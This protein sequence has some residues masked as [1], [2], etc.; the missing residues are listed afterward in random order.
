MDTNTPTE[1]QSVLEW[2]VKKISVKID[3]EL[4]EIDIRA[5]FSRIGIK[6]KDLL[7]LVSELGTQLKRKLPSTLGFDYPNIHALA[8]FL[9]GTS[10]CRKISFSREGFND[11]YNK[12]DQLKGQRITEEMAFDSEYLKDAIAVVGMGCR[13]PGGCDTP[14]AFWQFLERGG[15]GIAEV[16]ADR[17]DVDFFYDK[18]PAI[19][20]KMTTRWGGF[21]D[22]IDQ[23]DPAFFG[24][25]PREARGVDP[26]QRLIMEVGWETLEDAG[27]IPAQLKGSKTGV[28]VGISGSDYGRLLF[29]EP[30]MLNLYS[31]TGNSTSIAANRLSYFLGLRGPSIALDTACSSSLVAVDLACKD[32]KN[33]NCNLALAGGVN[34]ILSPEMTIIFSKANLMAPDGRCKTFDSSADGYVRSE[35]CGMVALKRYSDA[36]NDGN[37]IY[38]L[39]RGTH[40]NQDG[41]STGLTVPNGLAQEIL[42]KDS[43]GKAGVKPSRVSYAETHGTG[44][45]IGDPIEVNSLGNV[46]GKGRS[47]TGPL[48]IGSVKT[49]IGHLEQAAGIAGLIKVLLSLKH[50]K[51]PS[52]LHFKEI[53]PMIS[54]D[55]I[56]AVIPQ[57]E[58]P[59]LPG[60][61]KRIA[62]VS[63]F[64][65][66][67]VN[68]HVVV[69]EA[70]PQ[71]KADNEQGVPC[72]LLT[73]SARDEKTLIDMADRYTKYLQSHPDT[74]TGSVCYTANAC[75]SDFSQRL[76]I[77]GE[78]TEELKNGLKT[79]LNNSFH[80]EVYSAKSQFDS[81]PAFLFTGQG[82]QYAGM[83]RE[84]YQTQPVFR[85]EM[86]RCNEILLK[87][88]QINLLSLIYD[89]HD[90]A[91][92]DQTAN[93]QPALFSLEYSMACMYQAWGI[94]PSVVMG[95]SVGEFVAAC[96]AGVFS[97]EDGLK[98]I[99]E[100]GRLI[101]K[102][103]QGGKM[104]VFFTGLVDIEAAISP[105][106]QDLSIAA[107]NGLG[108]IVVS[109]IGKAVDEI[110][111]SLSSKG[112]QHVLLPVS[113]AFHSILMEPMLEDFRK[114]AMEITYEIPKIPYV[115]NVTGKMIEKDEVCSPDYWCR[116]IRSTVRFE[117][118]IQSL[119]KGGCNLFLEIG[120][121]PVLSGMASAILP[122]DEA[123]FAPS[124]KK[125][126]TDLRSILGGLG[127]LYTQGVEINWKELHRP[128][129]KAVISLP[130]YPFQRRRY[131][132]KDIE[133][134]SVSSEPENDI[135]CLSQEVSKTIEK[136]T[137][138]RSNSDFSIDQ[139]NNA[140]LDEKETLIFNYIS[141][142]V[143]EVMG[144]DAGMH[145]DP[146]I[147]LMEMGLDSL[148]V[149]ELRD[150]FIKGSGVNITLVEFANN[151]T[152]KQLSETMLERL[153]GVKDSEA[154]DTTLPQIVQQPDQR[155]DPFPLTDIQNAYWMGRNGELSLGHVSCH[156][157]PEVDIVDLDMDR[158][159]KAVSKLINR[160]EILRAV[161]LPYG[162]QQ[163]LEQVP[164][165]YEI[166][167][168]DLR[169]CDPD[170]QKTK[171]DDIR[172]Q[173]SHQINPSDTGPLFEIRA[174][175]L[176]EEI[177][178]LHVSFDLLIGD[179]WSFNILISDLYKYYLDPET[180]LPEL[181][182]SFRDYVLTQEKVKSTR[183]YQ[184]SM[185]YWKNRLSDLLPS[186]DLP[187][188][189]KTDEINKQ[190]FVR[191]KSRME[192]N[193][194]NNLKDRA[195][196]S[197]LTPSG[198]LL[199]AFSEVL[200][201]W[202]K[203]SDFTLNL[204][205]FNRLPLHE[206]VNEIVGDFT[207]TLLLEINNSAH[208]SFEERARKIRDRL[209]E[210]LE[211]R[212]VSG[213]EILR[214]LNRQKSLESND[215]YPIVFTS[216]LPHGDQIK[217]ATT[218][219]LP[220]ELSIDLV[221][222]ISQTP[223]VWLD[224]QIYEQNGELT[225]NWDVVE[226]L[227]PDGM[228]DDMFEVY[229]TLIN[230]LAD[231]EDIWK[232]TNLKLVPETQVEQRKTVNDTNVP[233]SGE[234]LHTLFDK[235]AIQQP[236]KEAIVT[237]K[238]RMNYGELAS[239]SEEIG[240]ILRAE[241]ALSNTLVAVVMEKGWEQVV[242][243]LGI[244]Y[245]GAAYV[246]VD[247]SMPK[248]RLYQ[249]LKNGEVDLVLTQSW[250]EEEISWPEGI[251]SFSVDQSGCSEK[252]EPL[253]PVQ[254]QSD[255]AYVIY[256]S[257]STGQ[258]KGVM[259][260]HKG[261]VNTILDVNSRFHISGKDKVLAL[262]ELSF[263][264][265]VYD[266]FGALSAGGTIIIPDTESRK[267]PAHWHQLM[268]M[269]QVTVWNSAPQLMQMYTEYMSIRGEGLS[270][271]L[272]LVLMSGDWI[273]LDLPGKIKSISPDVKI[274][275]L[276][277]ATE[278]SIWSIFYPVN[279]I[280]PAWKSIPY[281]QP[282]SNQKFY[283]F[284]NDMEV[285]PDWVPGQLYIAG[286]GLAKGYWRDEEKTK[287][288]FLKHF[289][290][291]ETLY[292]TGDLGRF[293]PDGNIEFLGREDF[294]VKIR[295]HRIELGEIEATLKKHPGVRDAVVTTV[296]DPRESRRLVGYVI[297]DHESTSSLFDIENVN[298][299]EKKMLW[300]S[301]LN[302][303]AKQMQQLPKEFTPRLLS[304][305]LENLEYLSFVYICRALISVGA[306]NKPGQQYTATTLIDDCGIQPRYLKLV[307]QWLDILEEEGLLKRNGDDIFVNHEALSANSSDIKISLELEQDPEWKEYVENL[308]L[309]FERGSKYYAQL[310]KGEVDPLWL[311]FS[312]EPLLSPEHLIQLLPVTYFR[313][314][315]VKRFL[316]VV[317]EKSSKEKPLR[318]LEVGART[319]VTTELLLPVLSHEQTIYTYTDESNFFIGKGKD[320]FKDYSFV[321]YQLLDID[322]S[323][324]DQ[325]YD[326]HC[327]DIIITS[328]SLHRA[329]NVEA[330]SHHL[331]SLLAPGGFLFALEMTRNSRLINISV[332]F[333]EEFD[334]FQDQRKENGLPLFSINEWN[335]ILCSSGFENFAA[336]PE[337]SS[338][339]EPHFHQNVMVV[340][341][342]NYVK[343]FNP[344]ELVDI[345]HQNLPKYM[346]PSTFIPL[347]ELPLTANGK[348]DRQKLPIPE[349]V[350]AE[351]G[352][353]FV[354]P[355][356]S[357]EASLADVWGQVLDIERIGI[358]DNF[359]ELGG[360]SLLAVQL[361]T[362]MSNTYNV[363]LSLERLMAAPTIAE[364]SDHIN[365]LVQKQAGREDTVV[366][367]PQITP[368]PG[369]EYIPFPLTDIQQA[370]LIGRSG[371][372]ELGNVSTH[373]Y[374]EF[375]SVG[376]EHERL[377]H[378]WQRLINQHGMMRT[379]ILPDGQQQQILK[380]VPL[381]QI[382]MLDLRGEDQETVESELMRLRDEMS[383]QLISTDQWP[384][385]DVR[386]SCFDK[387][388]VRLHISFDNLIFDGWSMFHL[389]SEWSRLYNDPDA[390]LPPL[391]LS[392]RD[393]VLAQKKINGS[394]L[395]QR[396]EEY[397][398]N[399]LPNIPP[400]PE[401]PLAKNP[402][403]FSQQRFSRLDSRLNRETWQQLKKRAAKLGLTPSGVL[404]TAYAEILGAWSKHPQLTINLTLF[405]RPEIHPQLNDIIGDFTSLT[406]LAVDNS[407]R[408]TFLERGKILQ[409]QL[410]Q[411]LDH[412]YVGGI[413]V[414]RELAKQRGER[415]GALMP[416][417][418]TSALGVDQEHENDSWENW[419]D[420]LIYNISQTPQV[421]LDH[422]VW[423]QNEELV[424]VWD[425]VEGLFPEKLL[426]DMF[427]AYCNLLKRLADKEKAWQ[428]TTFKL[429]PA[430]QLEKR[431]EV[432]A[433]EAPVSSEMLHTLFT[434]QVQQRPNQLAVI[435][436]NRALSYEELWSNSNQ[437]GHLLREKGAQ[438]NALIAVVMEK[439][440]EQIVATLG[441][442]QSGAAYLPIDPKLP[443][444]RLWY[445]LENG[446]VCL[447]LTQS[448][449]EMEI[450]W[451]D[452]LEIFP[453]DTMELTE[454]YSY[455]LEPIQRP[456]DLAYV[457]YTSGSTGYPKGVMIDHRGA[458]NTILDVNKRF[459]VEPKDKILAISNLNFDLS[460]YD[461]FGTLA[462]GGTMVLPDAEKTK[463]PAHWAELIAK[464]QITIWNTVPTMMQM[465]VEYTTGKT[466]DVSLPLC[467]VL[468]SGDWI[469]HD[470]PDKIMELNDGVQ[471]VSLG[472]AT[473]ASI[474]S[475]LYP[476]GK[477][478]LNW[479]SIPYGR[480]IANQHYYVLNAMLEDCPVWVSGQLYIG[481]IGL[482]KGY[483]RDEEK[484]KAA[485]IHHPETGERLYRTGDI[486]RYLPDGD[487]EFLGR[488]DSQVKIGGYRIE[489][490]EIETAL[491]QHQ[492][493]RD[494]VVVTEGEPLSL[495][496]AVVLHKDSSGIVEQ[497]IGK[498]L[499]TFL[500][501]QLP[502]YMI[503]KKITPLE[504]L[505]LNANGKVDKK[506][507][508][509]TLKK[510]QSISSPVISEPPRDA[511]E[512]Q[513]AEIWVDN[514]QVQ[515]LSRNDD[516]F[517]HGGDSLKATRIIGQL[518]TQQ[519]APMGV[520]LRTLFMAPTIATFAEQIRIQWSEKT[521][522][523]E[524]KQQQN[525]EEGVL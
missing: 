523:Q 356:T 433:T 218:I 519:I 438:P 333:I 245:S 374:F 395:Y 89:E 158:F 492:E 200:A 154:S 138:L 100:R 210:D 234:M 303:G 92:L 393:Y 281:G 267:N 462:A 237:S 67:G 178:R 262:S 509:Q 194:W 1:I 369:Q 150:R 56:P 477:V 81:K 513:L 11:L 287:A 390:S 294:Q 113:H 136:P 86:N 494:A 181:E 179:G 68:A 278:A 439:G 110:C 359:F 376:L 227:F 123:I 313:N 78:N 504:A 407:S 496:A 326:T 238:F 518:Q 205:M 6:S 304:V 357:M 52:H 209:W 467:L 222:C 172:N 463:E 212:Y 190:R 22:Q 483:W 305:F 498:E 286:A 107:I 112:I 324:Q 3:R 42:I 413:Q 76:A 487:L 248:E 271:R 226:G 257:G 315:I 396:D 330:A 307:E 346:I 332:G 302:A 372:Y 10:D 128:Y 411:D 511:L 166:K 503:P 189:K 29:Q 424:L 375:E 77:L 353:N 9:E 425:A 430:Y 389:I 479:K 403:S 342:S 242:A 493:V 517:L 198:V 139:I 270:H 231:E 96:I 345:L 98:L 18:N 385:F 14:E 151:S 57:E 203:S 15:D 47:E 314:D 133:K 426:D 383:H 476:V 311:F 316:E 280:D 34:L 171:L 143:T 486:G 470:L 331:Q 54:L 355:R 91:L 51:I 520:S 229:C 79:F 469:P 406:L 85:K 525:F 152:L 416:V 382:K 37:Q 121:N 45:P 459:R 259:I 153:G 417:V 478:N 59:W 13:F 454:E 423:E 380:E 142:Q 124:L 155:Y 421:W 505:P 358:W 223:Q 489:L 348:V 354:A 53:N 306:F 184:Q 434:D 296:G 370:Y 70:L 211:Y 475:N 144:L 253:I 323:P 435:S 516:F 320:K 114:T 384:L 207:T 33:R 30:S 58:T 261:A 27:E 458:V 260:D 225:L 69:E 446:E 193:R 132:F 338:S 432:N 88:H 202:S 410:W 340:Q 116:H 95:H 25:S 427:D 221:Y 402:K 177:T 269:E 283:V 186:P 249:I 362:R 208:I 167:I 451:P 23:F 484:T 104:A 474:W 391:D 175:L 319:G 169:G 481:G 500:M 43:L 392:F 394:K 290:T 293:L 455:P 381:Y 251:R 180:K 49:N 507:I 241:G 20:G 236:E 39:I 252:K 149:I 308:L 521:Q 329:R 508:A 422:Q 161:I 93:T 360:D 310:L 277:G 272:K 40:V 146:D 464:E 191:L 266:I 468:L 7:A 448:W 256:T 436:S 443:K 337:N 224:H 258:P 254:N 339:D 125:G 137:N 461:I 350:Q 12:S 173:M 444:E 336:F 431:S 255:L 188:A 398:Y 103:P 102:L 106:G 215:G 162:Q 35:G 176:D 170:F 127:V 488:E 366:P 239:R 351:P 460:V 174:S 61:E 201:T 399:R 299:E 108:N 117:T 429:I 31:G 185:E 371:I 131:W 213:V 268:E 197:G 499:Q 327:Y 414:Q 165:A 364:L 445:L 36:L 216:L 66:G 514:L 465:L 265:S 317:Q 187:L 502:G 90:T 145:I 437:L 288:S 264:L 80:H 206:Q 168:Q 62:T 240:R 17:W 442:L 130:T 129:D 282:M 160:H 515:E 386:L 217:D 334:Y 420:N 349:N 120:S 105:F 325:G 19:P 250:V 297:P 273:P 300:D 74:D 400:A 415:Q 522:E 157:Y 220:D 291:G 94:K 289:E 147:K 408:I 87:K 524:D 84:L 65:F 363:E 491:K 26:Q 24:I 73:L 285:C 196:K 233:I 28:F 284:N 497:E 419:M 501:L 156:I 64:G 119:R 480:P 122:K 506:A 199:A 82:S 219:N 388:R 71:N 361:T 485:F 405:N 397:W 97:L 148:M 72:H 135:S 99:A 473:E 482:A 387:E 192:K 183:L 312:D 21:I 510:Y 379:V 44:T 512:Q 373:C 466:G 141:D 412:P 83:G 322:K 344:D 378:A 163:I 279:E 182:L 418:F 295:G 292:K 41:E 452:K 441:I 263:D 309:Y 298:L 109:G 243:V 8:N 343:Q 46:L 115:S 228:L 111:D 63:G 471:V 401:L 472:G 341:A 50:N 276:G 367:L 214:E 235:Q 409:Q 377:N 38:G 457:I 232:E 195:T 328:N 456:E 75:R 453:M 368:D 134:Q 318:I 490:G 5:P 60:E 244:L 404:L 48:V 450:E 118:S 274:V 335:T 4:D 301:L 440:W 204:P 347:E 126:I 2:L 159:N 449:L 246:P 275:S 428:E 352:E 16:P 55:S 447:V 247:A 321:Q 365:V 101:Q 164:P 32:L 140:E 495:A 230:R